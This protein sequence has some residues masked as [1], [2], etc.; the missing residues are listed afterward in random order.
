MTTDDDKPTLPPSLNMTPEEPPPEGETEDERLRC[1]HANARDERLNEHKK[2]QKARKHSVVEAMYSL[3]LTD[4]A[5][6]QSS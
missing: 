5:K 6:P 3:P 1:E 2:K 4:R